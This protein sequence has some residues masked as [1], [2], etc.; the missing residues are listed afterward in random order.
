MYL[1]L[2]RFSSS[3]YSGDF[4]K[5]DP[6]AAQLEENAEWSDQETLLLL[7]GLELFDDDWSKISEHV[8]TRTKDQCVLHFLKVNIEFFEI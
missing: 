5:M 3:L 4:I 8:G 1:N 6:Q 7:E 2:G